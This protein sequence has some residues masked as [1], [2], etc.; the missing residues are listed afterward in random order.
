MDPNRQNF[1]VSIWDLSSLGTEFGL[2]FIGFVLGGN[3]LDDLFKTSPLGILLGSILG[4]AAAIYH[5]IKRT[6]DFK[7]SKK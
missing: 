6:N 1:A 4:F 2:I 5:I 3:Y 7:N